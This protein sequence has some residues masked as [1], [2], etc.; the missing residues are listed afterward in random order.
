MRR[1]KESLFPPEYP[2]RVR[3][4]FSPS[5][6]LQFIPDIIMRVF[7]FGQLVAASASA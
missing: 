5:D 6:P 4:L 1:L 2:K 3:R 7:I